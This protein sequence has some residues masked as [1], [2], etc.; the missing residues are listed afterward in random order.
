MKYGFGGVI[1]E[2]SVLD[3]M[4]D[5]VDPKAIDALAEPKPHHVV[6]RF[7]H[8]GIAPVQVGLRSEEGM[9]II[10]ARCLFILP[11]SAAEF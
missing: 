2:F 6:D 7:A 9:V 10:L 11:S 1:A 5:Y 3:Q 8:L 4:P